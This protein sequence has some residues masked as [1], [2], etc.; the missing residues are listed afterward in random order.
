MR[1]VRTLVG[2]EFREF[3]ANPAVILPVAI[4]V[5]ACVALPFVVVVAL[6]HALGEPLASDRNLHQIVAAAARTLPQLSAL[7]PDAAIEAFLFQ[8]FLLLF[9]IAP[10]VGAVSLAS[11]SVVGEKQGRTLEPLLTSPL[12]T[13]ELLVAKALASFLPAMAIEIMGL[14][15]YC[16]LV[17]LLA[18]PGV[19]AS[20]LSGRTIVLVALVGPLALLTAVQMTI[21]ISSRVSDPRSAQ[22]IA[23]LL[24]VPFAMMLVGQIAG[25]FVISTSILLLVAAALAAIWLALVG[26]SVALFDRE[27]ILT[28]WR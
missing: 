27:S 1:R 3:R 24:V 28:R 12:T 5:L 22:Q 26:F 20:L 21:A 11:Y 16:G 14:T 25:A 23:V 19:V 9:L 7:A 4:V 2:K 17:G 10:V 18:R 8:Q 13:A 6:P 15:A